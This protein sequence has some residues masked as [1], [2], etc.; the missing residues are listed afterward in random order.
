MT[1]L[2][3]TID[4]LERRL[5][6]GDLDFLNRRLLLRQMFETAAADARAEGYHEGMRDAQDAHRAAEREM[7]DGIAA[8]NAARGD[9]G[10]E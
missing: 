8:H 4:V 6:K 1:R 10:D 3:D 9:S 7:L 5:D 2:R